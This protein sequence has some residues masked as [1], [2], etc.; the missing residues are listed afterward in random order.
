VASGVSTIANLRLDAVELH[1]AVHPTAL[2]GPLHCSLSPSSTKKA[3][4]AAR[5]STTMPTC[6]MRWIVMCWTVA[7][8][9]PSYSV[10]RLRDRWGLARSQLVL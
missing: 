4:A 1:H 2:D 5:S 3:A 6:S 10:P 9:R 7:T 8:P